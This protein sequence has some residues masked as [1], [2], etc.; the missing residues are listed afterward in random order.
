MFIHSLLAYIPH[1]QFRLK[2]S[3]ASPSKLIEC[4][5]FLI[6]K[7]LNTFNSK[8]PLA[9]PMLTATLF[10]MTYAHTIVKA[11]HYVGLTLPGIIEEPGSFSGRDSSPRPLQGPLP[12]NLIS[13]PIFIN[14]TA[15]VFK[16][17][18]K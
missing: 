7:G 8:C 16:D 18:L 9:P 12:K 17:P 6:I 13:L 1:T 4:N 10:P 5:T 11:S 3:Q 15:S 14:E 2:D